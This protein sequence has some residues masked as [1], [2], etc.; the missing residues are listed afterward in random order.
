MSK[1]LKYPVIT[2]GREY[3]AYGRTVAAALSERLGIPYYDKDFIRQTVIESG[4]SED[5]VK[6]EGETMTGF[7]KLLDDFLNTTASY[8]SS[9]DRIFE[10]QSDVILELAQTPCIIVGRCANHVLDKHNIESFHIFLYAD[11]PHR[12]KRA[13]ELHPDL[14]EEHLKKVIKKQDTLRQ[15]YYKN[16][17]GEDIRYF[18]NYNIC[19]DTGKIGIDQTV[20]LLAELLTAR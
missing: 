5:D 4:F 15:T 20:D 1:T 13:A 16:Y 8:P 12:M 7:S 2:I 18:N 14:D 19:I 10:A 3:C 6:E 11:L 17:T 9:Y